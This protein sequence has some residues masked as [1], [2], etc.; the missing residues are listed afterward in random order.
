MGALLLAARPF[1]TL[2][3]TEYMNAI[4]SVA[5]NLAQ[6]VSALS[7]GEALKLVAGRAP[8]VL[9]QLHMGPFGPGLQV[10]Q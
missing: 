4:L 7:Y 1:A 3:V 10:V 6:P 2:A 9:Y 5:K 8:L